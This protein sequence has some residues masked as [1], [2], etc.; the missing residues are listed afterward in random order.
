MRDNFTSV[1]VHRQDEAKLIGEYEKKGYELVERTKPTVIAQ[2]G[3]V[4]LIFKLVTP[5]QG[6]PSDDPK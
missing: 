2:R 3:F 5:A 4:K 6:T 1:H